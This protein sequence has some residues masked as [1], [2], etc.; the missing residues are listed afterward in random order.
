VDGRAKLIVGDG[1]LDVGK[2]SE[3]R[4]G[5]DPGAVYDD[6]DAFLEWA[7]SIAGRPAPGGAPA[8]F[9]PFDP[10]T[11]GPPSPTPR[12]V[13]AV[14]LNYRAH[15]AESGFAPPSDPLFFTKYVS[16]FTGP[17]TDVVLPAGNVDWEC[18][19]VA[20][21][22][23]PARRIAA[24]RRLVTR[25]RPDRRAGPVRADPPTQRAPSRSSLWASRTP[26]SPPAGLSSSPPTSSPT[27][28]TWPSGARWT[29]RPCSP[30]APHS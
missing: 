2:A 29:D 12:Q 1:A 15:A 9:E 24:S 3:G 17:V 27:R 28:T 5:P 4:F 8:P 30:P 6:W 14:A 21:I 13:F 23:R 22:S 11:C 25:R 18:E 10:A 26:G 20:V 16:A 7:S 19:L